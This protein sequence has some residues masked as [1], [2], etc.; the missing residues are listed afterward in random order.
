[1]KSVGIRE[2]RD[3]ATQLIASGE[4]LVVERHGEPVGFFVPIVARDRRAG[5]VAL[6]RLGETVRGVLAKTGLTEDDLVAEFTGAD[7]ADEADD[8]ADETILI[9]SQTTSTSDGLSPQHASGR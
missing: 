5:A 6:D 9:S 1:M 3:R 8:D 2:F 4:T 7:L